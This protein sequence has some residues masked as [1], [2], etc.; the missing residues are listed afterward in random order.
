M[1][2]GVF[3][4]IQKD[5]MEI[6]GTWWRFCRIIFLRFSEFWNDSSGVH[7]IWKRFE[8]IKNGFS[9]DSE[10]IFKHFRVF[11]RS[12]KIWSKLCQLFF[13]KTQLFPTGR[14]SKK[15]LPS[16]SGSFMTVSL[17]VS[18]SKC[19]SSTFLA[20]HARAIIPHSHVINEFLK[21]FFRRLWEKKWREYWF[22]HRYWVLWGFFVPNCDENSLKSINNTLNS[23]KN[24]ISTLH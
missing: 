23:N 16:I 2:W 9:R 8:K 11:W 19:I 7:K 20:I 4:E 13:F 21:C 12:L 3:K 22:R 6:Q 14:T 10:V 15:S 5:L 24:Q 1:F 17:H 18:H